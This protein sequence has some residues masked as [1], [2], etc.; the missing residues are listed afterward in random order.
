MA[1]AI[2]DAEMF[3]L[4]LEMGGFTFPNRDAVVADFQ[5]AVATSS[6]E[7][8]IAALMD[9]G[10]V[11]KHHPVVKD[12]LGTIGVE[13]G[14]ANDLLRAAVG[15]Q[16]GDTLKEGGGGSRWTG[17]DVLLIKHAAEKKLQAN[18]WSARGKK[19]K[20]AATLASFKSRSSALSGDA[21]SSWSSSG[22]STKSFVSYKLGGRK[23]EKIDEAAEAA[24]DKLARMKLG[25]SPMKNEEIEI[26]LGEAEE[27]DELHRAI[28]GLHFPAGELHGQPVKRPSPAP[29]FG[30]EREDAGAV[31]A[32]SPIPMKALSPVRA[33]ALSPAPTKMVSP[34]AVS[35]VCARELVLNKG[36]LYGAKTDVR[37]RLEYPKKQ[38]SCGPAPARSPL[39]QKNYDDDEDEPKTPLTPQSLRH[40]D[41]KTKK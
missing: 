38:A 31:K 29:T 23:L 10:T 41:L 19:T 9:H 3:I 33:K 20:D 28:P 4:F 39:K 37:S 13:E 27:E 18:A 12:Y 8:L 32:I 26:D 24:A 34:K 35:P 21:S 17:T 25:E 22:G 36:K 40:H 2:V 30:G 11:S 14:T 15:L 6:V 16:T 5:E 1:C 7:L